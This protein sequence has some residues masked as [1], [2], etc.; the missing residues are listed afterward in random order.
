M[1]WF[2][3]YCDFLTNI[4]LFLTLDLYI[5][6]SQ[7][8]ISTKR[9][10]IIKIIYIFWECILSF[11]PEVPYYD[12]I[13]P[14]LYFLYII[15][16]TKS[17]LWKRLVLFIQFY[18]YYFIS[19]I[20]ITV[21]HTIITWDLIIY[22]NNEVYAKYFN[23]IGYFI[24]YVILYMYIIIQKLSDFPTG[25]I[26]K[27]YFLT[28]TSIMVTLLVVCSM[29]LGSTILTQ[30][31][32]VHL[33]F[34][35]LLVIAFLSL[36]IYRKVVFVLEENMLSKIEIEKNALEKDYAIQVEENIKK[37]AVLRHDFKNHM[38]ILH[39]YAKQDR[40]EELLEYMENLTTILSTATLVDTPS[41]LLSSLINAKKA[42]C[43]HAKVTFDFQ[44][45]FQVINIPDFD[46][47][48]IVSNILDNALTAAA[49]R[50]DGY[51]KLN[52]FEQNGYLVFN[53][54]NNHK[55]II[56]KEGE[57]FVTTKTNQPQVHGL[58]LIS[59]RKTVTKLRGE[60]DIEHTD[61]TFHIKILVPNYK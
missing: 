58:G 21:L 47:I 14:F 54:E 30:E 61:D 32:I 43:E 53:C 29:F 22:A 10:H 23:V 6:N 20:I 42:D 49:K 41:N 40:K 5:K 12:I 15:S 51:I 18:L 19:T 44:W 8:S 52:M 59:V 36:S 7:I 16:T 60:L 26:Y 46:L 55:E 4:F 28:I 24:L 2:N 38:I 9:A 13:Q 45:D 17:T 50:T 27:R 25:S 3:I 57:R 35:L 37:L 34:S 48:T 11:L 1:Q 56:T 33:F 31:D 39:G